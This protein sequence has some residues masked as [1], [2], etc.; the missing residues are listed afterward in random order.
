MLGRSACTG[1]VLHGGIAT[2]T[3]AIVFRASAGRAG[4]PGCG[5][6]LRKHYSGGKVLME[7]FGNETVTFSLPLPLGHIVYEGSFRQWQPQTWPI[8]RVTASA[9]SSCDARRE[10]LTKCSGVCMAALSWPVTAWSTG[11]PS[12]SSTLRSGAVRQPGA[13]SSL[14]GTPRTARLRP[15]GR[16]RATRVRRNPQFAPDPRESA[17]SQ[18]LAPCPPRPP[19]GP[20]ASAPP[21]TTRQPSSLSRTSSARAR[22]SAGARQ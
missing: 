2:L 7:S 16:D 19:R 21:A 15:L 1:L 4:E 12:G 6:W 9:G 22:C 13:G 17:G 20:S 14:P 11:I 18:T 10:L 3:E 5:N 8:P